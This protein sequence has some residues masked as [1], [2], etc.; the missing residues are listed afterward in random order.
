MPYAVAWIVASGVFLAADLLWLSHAL[1]RL[2]KPE[3]GHLLAPSFNFWSAAAF[4]A[5]YTAGIVALAV[6]PAL[7][8]RSLPRAALLGA[9]LGFVAYAAY[10]LTNLATLDRWSLKLA[11]IDMA[12]GTFATSI[13]AAAAF[14]AAHR[15]AS[16]Q[17]ERRR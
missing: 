8:R 6:A 14:G 15:V 10:D 11:L 13:A 3:I 9:V 7:D 12:W 4:Y 2:Y 17:R 1:P 5:V 16:R